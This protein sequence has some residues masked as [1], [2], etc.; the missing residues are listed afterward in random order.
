[1]GK[2]HHLKDMDA[3]EAAVASAPNVSPFL[4]AHYGLTSDTVR[5]YHAISRGFIVSGILRRVDAKR[6][7]LGQFIKEEIS[8]PLGITYFCGIPVDE[9]EKYSYADMTQIPK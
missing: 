7:T 1:M 5:C 9:Q 2:A 3:L 4:G 8:E 6:R